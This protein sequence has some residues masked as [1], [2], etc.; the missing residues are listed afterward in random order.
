MLRRAHCVQ[1][2][3]W[4]GIGIARRNVQRLAPDPTRCLPSRRMPKWDGL[5]SLS[6][7]VL[8]PLLRAMDWEEQRSW[9]SS[10]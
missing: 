8:A 2:K 4:C 1:V 3:M 6:D 9:S 5:K 7:H 10:G